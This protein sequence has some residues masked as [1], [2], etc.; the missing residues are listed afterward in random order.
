MQSLWENDS[1]VYQNLGVGNSVNFRN[2]RREERPENEFG[3][4]TRRFRTDLQCSEAH[5]E[6]FKNCEEKQ[7]MKNCR[8]KK[9]KRHSH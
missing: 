8:S 2:L 1:A 4:G 5:A 9:Q 6:L 3:A 7:D